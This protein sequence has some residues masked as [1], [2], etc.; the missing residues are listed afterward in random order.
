[1]N[2]AKTYTNPPAIAIDQSKTYTAVMETTKGTMTFE[3]YASES[4]VTVN[5]FVFLAREGFYNDT[6]FHRIISDFMIQGG[7]PLGTGTGGPGYQFEDEPITR[8]YEKGTIAMANSGA[9]TNGSQFFIM[10]TDYDLQKDYVIFGKLKVGQEVLD[11]IAGT[12]VVDNGRGEVSKPTEDVLIKSVT[13][14]EQ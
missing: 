13:I 7:D 9:N 12:P 4:P 2:Q 3:L 10:T 11:V 1:M 14:T 5:N 8:D 6:K